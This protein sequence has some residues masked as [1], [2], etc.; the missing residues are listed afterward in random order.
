MNHLTLKRSIQ[1]ISPGAQF[2]LNGDPEN[3]EEYQEN[4]QWLQDGSA[5]TWD[6]VVAVSTT[7]EAKVT[8]EVYKSKRQVEYPTIV[9]Q[10]DMQYHDLVEGT[11]TW[12]DFVEAVKNKYPKP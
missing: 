6:E 10:L 12:K 11:T 4:M 9:D 5:P 3:A 2:A 8:A 7:V 1:K